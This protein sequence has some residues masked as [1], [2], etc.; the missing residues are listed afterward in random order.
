[1]E[2]Q[3]GV[4]IIKKI[5]NN[6]FSLDLKKININIM[7]TLVL[8][9]LIIPLFSNAQIGEAEVVSETVHIGYNNNMTKF[10]SLSYSL[11]ADGGKVYHL[12]YRNMEYQN[13]DTYESLFFKATD[14]EFEYLYNFLKEGLKDD[15]GKTLKIGS[16]EIFVKR[17][18]KAVQINNITEGVAKSYFWLLS[19]DL[20][21]LFG[22]R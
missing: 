17:M 13:L 3:E 11:D 8:L 16:S 4:E 20:E 6:I 10:H 22:K 9:L 5:I 12:H 21:R 14:S 18:G 15:V 19:K 7:K 1:M 2:F